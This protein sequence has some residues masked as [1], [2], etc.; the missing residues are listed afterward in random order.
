M[1]LFPRAILH[2]LKRSDWN[3]EMQ[4]IYAPCTVKPSMGFAAILRHVWS[5]GFQS[6]VRVGLI[7]AIQYR[8]ADG[9]IE[10][11]YL[12]SLRNDRDPYRTCLD[13]VADIAVLL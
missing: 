9:I 8:A 3:I 6:L 10:I 13:K 11:Y 12:F 2:R 7:D 1:T 4:A 5:L